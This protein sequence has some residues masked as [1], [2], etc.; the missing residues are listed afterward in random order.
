[1]RTTLLRVLYSPFVYP[2][3]LLFAA[4]FLIVSESSYHQS[5]EAMDDT[6]RMATGRQTLQRLQQQISDAESGQRGYLITG[7]QEFLD[8]YRVAVRSVGLTQREL[9]DYY[10]KERPERSQLVR[11]LTDLVTA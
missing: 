4:A 6:G 9:I 8:P 3:A 5:V 11:D 7:Q 10:A 2:A 1:M